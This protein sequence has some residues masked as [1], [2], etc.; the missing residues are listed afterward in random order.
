VYDSLPLMGLGFN[1]GMDIHGEKRNGG[2]GL[3]KTLT[4]KKVVLDK[5]IPGCVSKEVSWFEFRLQSWDLKGLETF[6]GKRDGDILMG[7]GFNIGMDIH[8]EKR[9][10]GFGL[11]KTLTVKKVVFVYPR[12][13][14][15]LSFGF[16]LGT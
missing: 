13:S 11:N 1:I 2:F 5:I 15:G 3:N 12:R 9:N 4:V 6:W 16:S 8:G 10:G 7:L 14:H